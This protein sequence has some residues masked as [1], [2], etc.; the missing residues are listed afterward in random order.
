MQ[1][2]VHLLKLTICLTLL[3][4]V[5]FPLRAQDTSRTRELIIRVIA[6]DPAWNPL[7]HGSK[8][9][10]DTVSDRPFA[11]V[12][13]RDI[14]FALSQVEWDGQRLYYDSTRLGYLALT[15]PGAK[16]RLIVRHPDY[17]PVDKMV[18]FLR[19][20]DTQIVIQLY[21]QSDF[22][23]PDLY[24]GHIYLSDPRRFQKNT[25]SLAPTDSLHSP[26]SAW[27]GCIVGR[28]WPSVDQI[29]NTMYSGYH[30]YFK[31]HRIK[32]R[33]LKIGKENLQQWKKYLDK[34]GLRNYWIQPDCGI[35]LLAPNPGQSLEDFARGEVS[36]LSHQKWAGEVGMLMEA[37][38][39]GYIGAGFS[40]QITFC[41]EVSPEQ[42]KVMLDQEVRFLHFAW[43]RP[44]NCFTAD[45]DPALGLDIFSLASEWQMKPGVETAYVKTIPF[46]Q[47]NRPL[48]D[49]YL[50]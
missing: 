46:E 48:P 44:G 23:I 16:H 50:K 2:F 18:T 24:G 40:L 49:P 39:S 43:D 11:P 20:F 1:P 36:Y 17:Y 27:Q 37:K 29:M 19:P 12:H 25:I 32:V 4:L 6:E 31:E 28:V 9:P 8:C 45:V 34:H 38:A 26:P 21:R 10:C 13:R 35:I 7:D 3:V 33:D 22:D 15:Y 30:S 41:E 14:R 42:A 47:L 5:A